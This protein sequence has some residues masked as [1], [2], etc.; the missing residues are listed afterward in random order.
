MTRHFGYV[1]FE[2]NTQ[3]S[4]QERTDLEEHILQMS[5]KLMSFIC[6]PKLKTQSPSVVETL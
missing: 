1:F 2:N 3:P 6:I 5:N 4:H